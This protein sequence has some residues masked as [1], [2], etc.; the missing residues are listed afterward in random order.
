LVFI[1]V[2]FGICK[3]WVTVQSRDLGIEEEFKSREI[4]GEQGVAQKEEH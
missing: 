1:S 2:D 3:L 4:H